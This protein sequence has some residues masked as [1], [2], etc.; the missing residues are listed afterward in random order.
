MPSERVHELARRHPEDFR[1]VAEKCG[2]KT[3]QIMKQLLRQE[4][5]TAAPVPA[6]D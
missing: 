6:D 1:S 4:S 2:G 5:G 3:E